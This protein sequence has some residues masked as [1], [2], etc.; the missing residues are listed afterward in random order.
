MNKGIPGLGASK[1]RQ[2]GNKI[3]K[4]T[5]SSF[6][7]GKTTLMR[8]QKLPHCFHMNLIFQGQLADRKI[9]F[10]QMMEANH[11]LFGSAFP[12]IHFKGDSGYEYQL[13]LGYEIKS[14]LVKHSL[15]NLE[16]YAFYA[17]IYLKNRQN[18]YIMTKAHRLKAGSSHFGLKG[19][20]IKGLGFFVEGVIPNKKNFGNEKFVKKALFGVSYHVKF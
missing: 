18:Q 14:D 3:V 11:T 13:K 19:D 6:W 15:E 17:Q 5:R 10:S 12:D 4:T 20:V 8:Q 1:D 9:P 7:I 16:L 2:S